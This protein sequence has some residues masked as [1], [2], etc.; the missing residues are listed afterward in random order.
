MLVSV[1]VSV[2]VRVRVMRRLLSEVVVRVMDSSWSGLQPVVQHILILHRFLCVIILL[3]IIT[4]LKH[5]VLVVRSDKVIFITNAAI[6]AFQRRL[7][8]VVARNT[9]LLRGGGA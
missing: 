5:K 8:L 2:R 7:V 6:P 1:S 3:L 4:I 9:R